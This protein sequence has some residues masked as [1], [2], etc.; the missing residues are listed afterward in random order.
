MQRAV[1]FQCLPHL[2]AR[3]PLCPQLQKKN[4]VIILSG[5]QSAK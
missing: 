2:K 4:A 3:K 1:A 5:E